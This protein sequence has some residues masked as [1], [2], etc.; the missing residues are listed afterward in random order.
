MAIHQICREIL[1]IAA[2]RTGRA[3]QSGAALAFH[4][5]TKS[6]S[7]GRRTG[8]IFS[9]TASAHRVRSI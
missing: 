3:S 1:K 4:S 5:R 6:A 9:A 7:T 8:D 2:Q